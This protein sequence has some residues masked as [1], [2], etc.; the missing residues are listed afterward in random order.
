MLRPRPRRPWRLEEIPTLEKESKKVGASEG[1]RTLDIQPVKRAKPWQRFRTLH[2]PWDVPRSDALT[3]YGRL[4]ILDI[5][6]AI[7]LADNLEILSCK[8]IQMGRRTFESRGFAAV[9]VLE[10]AAPDWK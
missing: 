8:L 7:V 4:R 3:A 1:I 2:V 6:H 5:F 9:D 10:D